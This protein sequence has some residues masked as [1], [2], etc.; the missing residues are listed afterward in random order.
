MPI[1]ANTWSTN[2]NVQSKTSL[3]RPVPV[4]GCPDRSSPPKFFGACGVT[5]MYQSFR[6]SYPGETGGRN[7]FR[8]PGYT[9]L[10]LGIGKSWKMP[11]GERHELQFRWEVF[12]VANFQPFTTLGGRS[13]WGIFPGSTDPAPNF[14]NFSD[15]QGN[16]RVMQVGLRYGF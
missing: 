9:N 11:Y 7:F 10:D 8:Y 6:N 2:W 13:G 15:I 5:A 4:N 12:N 14:S 16:P 3:I 1:D